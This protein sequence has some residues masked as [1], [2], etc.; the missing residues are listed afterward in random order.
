MFSKLTLLVLL[1]GLFYSNF[2][3]AEPVRLSQDEG[4]KGRFTQLRYLEGFEQ[5]IRSSGDFYVVSDV[6]LI[7]QTLVPIESRMEIDQEGIRQ[8][9]RGGEVTHIRVGQFPA[10]SFLKTAL[11][12]SLAGNWDY[13]ESL[14]GKK[15]VKSGDHWSLEYN[16]AADDPDLAFEKITFEIGDYLDKV[17]IVRTQGDRDVITFH[18][19]VRLPKS[20]V[21]EEFDQKA[22]AAQ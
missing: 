20:V 18:D 12:Q 21:Q 11:E 19:Q 16:P 10:L 22:E 5:P 17:E 8:S 3:V 14:A 6:G 1:C 4:L 2:T 15:L 13:L 9:V 7:W